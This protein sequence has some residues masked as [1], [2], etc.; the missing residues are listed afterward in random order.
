M[1]E[2]GHI[3]FGVAFRLFG[4]LFWYSGL[5]LSRRFPKDSKARTWV[6]WGGASMF[7]VVSGLQLLWLSHLP[8]H[9]RTQAEVEA[10]HRAHPH[11]IWPTVIVVTVALFVAQGVISMRQKRRNASLKLTSDRKTV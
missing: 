8:H 1:R 10:D 2:W 3:L 4:P 5:L 6:V 7:I 9:V 11:G